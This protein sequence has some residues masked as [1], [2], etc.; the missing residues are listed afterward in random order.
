MNYPTT[1]CKGALSA[2]NRAIRAFVGSRRGGVALPFALTA[3]PLTLMA[4]AAVDF[5]RASMVKSGLQDALD[6]AALTV[7]RS[8]VTTAGDVQ[9]LGQSALNANLKAFPRPS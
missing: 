1:P 9:S 3:V 5:N 2:L 7:G 8:T 4:M 6:A